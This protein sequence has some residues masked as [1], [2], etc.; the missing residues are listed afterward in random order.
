MFFEEEVYVVAFDGGAFV[1]DDAASVAGD[2]HDGA[3]GEEGGVGGDGAVF[4]VCAGGGEAYVFFLP[5]VGTG[6]VYSTTQSEPFAFPVATFFAGAITGGKY[7]DA[8]FFCASGGFDGLAG[9]KG[10]GEEEG[11][12]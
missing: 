1:L 2:F 8:F 9:G 12:K 4:G 5:F 11:E 3:E 10:G 6:G 7:G